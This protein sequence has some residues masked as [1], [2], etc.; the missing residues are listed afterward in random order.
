MSNKSLGIVLFLPYVVVVVVGA[1][2]ND[3]EPSV[4]FATP[5]NQLR[6]CISG[7]RK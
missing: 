4:S 3:D 6:A 7:A 1:D 5:P 2:D